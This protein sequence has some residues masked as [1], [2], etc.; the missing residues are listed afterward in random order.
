MVK[1]HL[2][3]ICVSIAAAPKLIQLCPTLCGPIGGSPPGSSVR[4]ILQARV[5]EWGAIAFSMFL[6]AEVIYR[7]PSLEFPAKQM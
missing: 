5:L 1:D 6:L 3:A 2:K 4:G 7:F